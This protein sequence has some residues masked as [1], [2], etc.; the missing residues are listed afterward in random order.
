MAQHDRP[1]TD[2][3]AIRRALANRQGKL[4]EPEDVFLAWL[5][6]LP[7]E[8]DIAAAARHEIIRLDAIAPLS[9]GPRRLREL[10]VAAAEEASRCDEESLYSR[11]L[12]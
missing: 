2:T 12:M 8:A 3:G 5:M 1:R 7:F 9:A 10:F 11:Y 4:P 6:Q